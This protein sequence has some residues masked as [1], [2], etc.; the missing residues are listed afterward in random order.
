MEKWRVFENKVMNVLLLY[1][2][3]NFLK[4]LC[5]TTLFCKATVPTD[6]SAGEL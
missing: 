4:S 2:V 1:T 6:V 3:G 5:R